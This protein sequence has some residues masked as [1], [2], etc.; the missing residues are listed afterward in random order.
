MENAL[1]GHMLVMLTWHKEG[2]GGWGL[3]MKE[4]VVKTTS[5][6]GFA[7]ISRNTTNCMEKAF[8]MGTRCCAIVGDS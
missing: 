5:R 2:Q 3:A 4:R 6:L 8:M 7:Q 1:G